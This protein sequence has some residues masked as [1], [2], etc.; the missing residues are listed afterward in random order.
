MDRSRSP[1]GHVGVGHHGNPLGGPTNT[2]W[3]RAPLSQLS[4]PAHLDFS[5][6]MT[7]STHVLQQNQP[8]HMGGMGSVPQYSSGTCGLL[9]PPARPHSGQQ[10]QVT[11]PWQQLFPQQSQAFVLGSPAPRPQVMLPR[12]F[13]ASV[14]Q[15]PA[16]VGSSPLANA[17]AILANE[18]QHA[19]MQAQ[20][21]GV[22]PAPQRS[23]EDL[24]REQEALQ[25]A[26]RQQEK[27]QELRSIEAKEGYFQPRLG[28]VLHGGAMS[29]YTVIQNKA[30]GF[31]VFSSV[32]AVADK[33]NKLIAMKVIRRQD[34]FLK[35]ARREVE[36]LQKVKDLAESDG[37]GARFVLKL[38]DSFMHGDH[39]CISFEKLESDLR[40]VGRQPLT[41]VIIYSKQI[42]LALRY[43]H[44]QVSLCHCDVKPDNLLL[45][46]DMQA[47]QLTDFGTARYSSEIQNIDELQPLF[48]RAPEVLV[49][50]PRGRKIDIWSAGCTIYEMT[51]GR[52]LLK[53]CTTLRE[54]MGEV[55]KLRGAV[56]ASMR[57][58]GRLST[59]YFSPQGFHPENGTGEGGSPVALDG[60][61]A[62]SILAEL[63]P[64][65]DLGAAKTK[66]DKVTAQE[67]ARA[68]LSKLIGSSIVAA[69]AAASKKK[70]QESTQCE[71]QLGYLATLI[72]HCMEVNPSD[73]ISAATAVNLSVFADVAVPED[74]DL[75]DA[76][77]LP[78]E[79]PP[80]LPPSEPLEPASAETS[81]T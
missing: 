21:P 38:R 64:Y 4:P 31:G 43:L 81:A 19:A 13:G 27:L 20:Y 35:Y 60:F 15:G 79:A 75:L 73:R 46:Y 71:R 66:A 56:P 42:M 32:W 62:T 2:A 76:P 48:Y 14:G 44:E 49:G 29:P 11:P 63:E 25:K 7:A 34:H 8:L 72:D 28:D 41:K 22:A 47:I 80:P 36:V 55:M 51:T 3:Q 69:G 26:K 74:V 39:L 37:E 12:S 77:P 45:R 33:N 58:E 70:K 61:K 9:G 6:A 78:L 59:L 54:V 40:S 5:Q 68:Q 17:Y 53:T 67:Q 18:N 30:L 23:A 65:A 52:I 57:S 24:A 16:M 50:A 1:I 10:L